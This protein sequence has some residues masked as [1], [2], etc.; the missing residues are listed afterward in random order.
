MPTD[1]LALSLAPLIVLALVVRTTYGRT[2]A[3][4][5]ERPPGLAGV[6]ARSSPRRVRVSSAPGVN[7]HAA[8]RRV[9][10]RVAGLWRPEAPYSVR[11]ESRL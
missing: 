1:A 6:A 10:L 5:V 3:P 2:R 9:L 4:V 11:G 7:H 8:R